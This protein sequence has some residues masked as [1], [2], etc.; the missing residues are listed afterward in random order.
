MRISTKLFCIWWLLRTFF[1]TENYVG[2]YWII[3]KL[4]LSLLVNKDV[5][6]PPALIPHFYLS[7][8]GEWLNAIDKILKNSSL[9]TYKSG[10][11]G[12]SSADKVII[13]FFYCSFQANKRKS[14]MFYKNSI[15]RRPSNRSRIEWRSLEIFWQFYIIRISVVL[16]IWILRIFGKSW[17][18]KGSFCCRVLM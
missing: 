2:T 9:F 17:R 11:T 12:S 16:A 18:R 1:S 13:T 8:M 10:W 5:E 7:A 14:S 15:Y 4:L 3:Y 6:L